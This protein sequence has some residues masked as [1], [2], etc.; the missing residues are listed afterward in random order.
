MRRISDLT[1]SHVSQSR[2]KRSQVCDFKR[3]VCRIGAKCVRREAMPLDALTERSKTHNWDAFT[4]THP[5]PQIDRFE[6]ISAQAPSGRNSPSY[7]RDFRYLLR[8]WP[9]AAK[10]PRHRQG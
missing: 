1:F 8:V 6:V 5:K 9:R 3:R 7:P 10:P 4:R 2:E